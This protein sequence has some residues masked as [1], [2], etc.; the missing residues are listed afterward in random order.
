MALR[1]RSMG[2]ARETA[3]GRAHAGRRHAEQHRQCGGGMAI[4]VG[5]LRTGSPARNRRACQ[6]DR[7]DVFRDRT[8]RSG[9]GP[10]CVNNQSHAKGSGP[11]SE[12]RRPVPL[13]ARG[14]ARA[15]SGATAKRTSSWCAKAAQAG[16]PRFPRCTLQ[17]RGWC[18]CAHHEA[19]GAGPRAIES[20]ILPKP[21]EPEPISLVY[22]FPV[23]AVGGGMSLPVSTM[24]Q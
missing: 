17:S 21:A 12:L 23:E 8:G 4:T 13:R 18:A 19:V 14:Q 11:I 1:D 7:A 24:S 16:H 22:A 9:I 20:F 10:V 5:V 3:A 15:L 2:S 6:E